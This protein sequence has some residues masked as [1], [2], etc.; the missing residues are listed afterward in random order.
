LNADFAEASMKMLGSLTLILGLILCLFY[1]LKRLRAGS[2]A[3]DRHARIRLLGTLNLAPKRAVALIEVCEQ[4]L[5][6]GI[7]TESVTLISRVERPAGSDTPD[8]S[9]TGKGKSFLSLLQKKSSA[10]DEKE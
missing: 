10:L 5:L 8:A 6:V 2:V 7:G 1:V 9:T 3:A 4:W